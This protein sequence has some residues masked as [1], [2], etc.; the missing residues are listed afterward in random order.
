MNFYLI[1]NGSGIEEFGI[2]DGLKQTVYKTPFKAA[3]DVNFLHKNFNMDE[4]DYE[5]ILDFLDE[6]E[7]GQI[8]LYLKSRKSKFKR[9][10]K[11]VISEI[12]GTTDET[13]IELWARLQ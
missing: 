3:K 2:D 1:Q 7:L 9:V 5:D 10:P 12:I 13:S 4:F 11:S 8:Y 6:R